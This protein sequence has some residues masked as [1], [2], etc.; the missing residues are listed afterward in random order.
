MGE[1]HF[2]EDELRVLFDAWVVHQ[3][4]EAFAPQDVFLPEC[5]RLA[6]AGWLERRMHGDDVVFRWSDQAEAAL[7]LSAA[8]TTAKESVN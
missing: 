7:N 8:M 3:D 1:Q 5:H 6:E 2:T 4:G